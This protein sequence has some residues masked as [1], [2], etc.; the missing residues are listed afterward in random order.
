MQ[1]PLL[2]NSQNVLT[3]L[4]NNPRRKKESVLLQSQDKPITV[5]DS[6]FIQEIEAY[7]NFAWSSNEKEKMGRCYFIKIII[8]DFPY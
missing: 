5:E 1:L 2:N 4:E 6:P 8:K 3:L 7:Q